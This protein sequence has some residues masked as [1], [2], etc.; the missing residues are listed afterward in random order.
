MYFKHFKKIWFRR[1]ISKEKLTGLTTDGESANIGK[2]SGLWVRLREY[3][4]RDIILCILCVTYR[5]DLAFSDIESMVT[6]VKHWKINIKSVASFYRGSAIRTDELYAI[7]E[8]KKVT[9][10][11]FP[12]FFCHPVKIP[13]KSAVFF[14]C[15]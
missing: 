8:K 6:E 9:F 7:S 13:K 12:Q 14:C 5:C 15:T 3:L 11:R 2:N 4:K 10:Y 1:Y